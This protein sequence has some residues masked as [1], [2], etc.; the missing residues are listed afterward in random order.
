MQFGIP[1]NVFRDTFRRRLW[2]K[3]GVDMGVRTVSRVGRICQSRIFTR[4]KK[5]MVMP[6]VK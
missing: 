4:N 3:F 6:V 2:V 5:D 1:G